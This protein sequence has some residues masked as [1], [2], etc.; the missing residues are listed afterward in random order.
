VLL[1]LIIKSGDI[2]LRCYSG[3]VLIRHLFFRL[4]DDSTKI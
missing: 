4:A 3:L 2:L 1:L